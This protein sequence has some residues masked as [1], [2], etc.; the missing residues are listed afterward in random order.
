MSYLFC[1]IRVYG[2]IL[3]LECWHFLVGAVSRVFSIGVGSIPG[4]SG[5]SSGRRTGISASAG[6]VSEGKTGNSCKGDTTSSSCSVG[7]SVA[8]DRRGVGSG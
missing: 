4:S 5:C 8:G 6:G 1:G 2:V 7:R 3:K